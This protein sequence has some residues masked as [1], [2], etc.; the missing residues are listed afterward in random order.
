VVLHVEN[1]KA[2]DLKVFLGRRRLLLSSRGAG[3]ALIAPD[4]FSRNTLPVTDK[5]LVVQIENS[6]WGV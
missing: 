2:S 4:M 5:L 6:P 1:A 3:S